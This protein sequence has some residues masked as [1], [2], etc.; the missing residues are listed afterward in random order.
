MNTEQLHSFVYYVF[1]DLL[2]VIAVA[3]FTKSMSLCILCM[4]VPL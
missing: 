2:E 4:P 1:I 3:D